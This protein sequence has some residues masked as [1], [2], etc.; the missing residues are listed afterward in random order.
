[1][2]VAA[3]ISE[4]YSN[5][6]RTLQARLM[7]RILFFL[8]FLGI[9]VSILAFAPHVLADDF[10]S[11]NNNSAIEKNADSGTAVPTPFDYLG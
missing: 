10:E 3:M 9:L 5:R 2:S 11:G 6:S 4:K 7:R 1:M 8:I